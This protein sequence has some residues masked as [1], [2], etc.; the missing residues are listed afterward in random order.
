M[1]ST[2]KAQVDPGVVDICIN[3]ACE[4]TFPDFAL[5]VCVNSRRNILNCVADDW[6]SFPGVFAEV[7]R[8]DLLITEWC[9]THYNGNCAA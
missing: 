1:F 4:P 8:A 5:C 6:N 7:A 9:S 3:N 2:V